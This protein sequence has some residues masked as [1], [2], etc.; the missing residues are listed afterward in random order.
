MHSFLDAK[1]MARTLRQAFAAR[2]C[3]VSQAES[4]ELVARQFGLP[5]WNVLAARIEQ[6]RPDAPELSMPDGWLATGQT[7][8]KLYQLGIDPELPGVAVIG[9]RL[10]RE[11]GADLGDKF[12]AFMQSIAANQYRGGRIRLSA[13]LRSEDVDRGSL[14]L[15]VDKEPGN[16]LAFDNM[17]EE[18][19]GRALTGTTGWTRREIVLPV[20]PEAASVHM[21]FLLHG[22]GRLRARNVVLEAVDDKVPLT[23]GWGSWLSEPTNLGFTRS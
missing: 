9:C 16:V 8:R 3:A 1:V 4:L 22:Y 2:G 19:G 14:W 17:L 20:A 15:R 6:V 10:P 11:A 13:E 23:T 5:N 12:A 18:R 7:D 21:G